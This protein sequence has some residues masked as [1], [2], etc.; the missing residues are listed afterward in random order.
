[1]RELT[2][3]SEPYP[4][5]AWRETVVRG[6]DQHNVAITGL[7]DYYPVGF[8]MRGARGD[9]LRRLDISIGKVEHAHDHYFARKV[10]QHREV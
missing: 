4:S 5:A 2:I 7:A 1:M 3:I 8:V 9:D 6:V 10:A